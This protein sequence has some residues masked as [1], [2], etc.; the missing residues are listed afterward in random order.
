ML[1]ISEANLNLL[2]NNK[3]LTGSTINFRQP[4]QGSLKAIPAN[5]GSATGIHQPSPRFHNAFRSTA[6]GV[7]KP[8]VYFNHANSNSRFPSNVGNVIKN[9]PVFSMINSSSAKKN[10]SDSVST[11]SS[12][13]LSSYNAYKRA[14]NK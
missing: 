11:P 5:P 2:P 1:K 6:D 8:P 7:K 13:T 9:I 4:S 10:T 14:A 3:S 12:G